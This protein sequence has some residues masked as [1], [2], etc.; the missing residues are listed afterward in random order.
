MPTNEERRDVAER[1]RHCDVSASGF[2]KRYTH[3]FNGS[4]KGCML[5]GKSEQQVSESLEWLADMIEPEPEPTCVL[6]FR[7]DD[8]FPAE[9]KY[10]CSRCHEKFAADGYDFKY[11]P[12]CRAKVVDE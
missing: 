12:Y 8:L 11:C 5:I 6:T 3:A 7:F 2:S 4:I 10:E 9:S 1:L